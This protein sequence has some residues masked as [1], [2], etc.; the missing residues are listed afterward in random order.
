MEIVVVMD[1]VR[2][3]H[4]YFPRASS[5]QSCGRCVW[6]RANVGVDEVLQCA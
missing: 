5:A 1:D 6:E 4:Q 3:F 2:H